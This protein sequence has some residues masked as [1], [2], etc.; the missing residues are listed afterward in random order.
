MEPE[1]TLGPVAEKERVLALDVLRGVAILGILV[2]NVEL[3]RGPDY[4]LEFA[5]LGTP[6][7][8][9]AL[10]GAL[11][12]VFAESKFITT[13]AFLFGLGFA[14]QGMRAESRGASPG[15]LLSSRMAVLLLFGIAH[16]VFI[17][18]GDI[19][20]TYALIGFVFLL[21]YR[22]RPRT[23]LLW[24]AVAV[25]V[26]FLLALLFASL[27]LLALFLDG[28]AQ[29]P[30]T[31]ET[32]LD[33]FRHL[34]ERAE[35][36][37]TSGSYAEMVA[38]RLREL[39]FMLPIS[40]FVFGPLVLAMMLLGAAVA[41]SGW[42]ADLSR[43]RAGIRRAALVGLGA[44]LPLNILYG[45]SRYAFDPQTSPVAALGLPALI[46]GAPLLAV[47]Y[48]AAITLLVQRSQGGALVRR[49]SAVGRLALTNYLAQSL[50]MT[51]IFYGFG[52]Y[53]SVGLAPAL[54]IAAVVL[55]LQLTFSPLY[56]QR[57][58]RGPAEWLWR[59]LTYSRRV[60]KT[61]SPK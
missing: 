59:R 58:F 61:H 41:R 37:Y 55:A 56:L 54:T 31:Q 43:H 49:L 13:L 33:F 15:G 52:L 7:G 2:V 42:T 40:L 29:A 24:A 39:L 34:A 9:D 17:W 22:R 25:A 57:F 12:S 48:I 1:R 35:A 28:G 27:M 11:I 19:L 10:L 20:V 16:A 50:I 3:F 44:G 18:S 30:E 4:L 14:L 23:L 36:A 32:Q 53:G 6:T 60:A 51:A 5:G 46:L 47:G 45:L 38:Q 26:P 21:F 8:L